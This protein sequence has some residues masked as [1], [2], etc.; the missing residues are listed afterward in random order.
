MKALTMFHIEE[1]Y[2]KLHKPVNKTY[3]KDHAFPTVVNA[4]YSSVENSIG[5][6]INKCVGVD[7]LI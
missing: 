7:I 2:G 1:S 5:K 3:W 4:F 6:F